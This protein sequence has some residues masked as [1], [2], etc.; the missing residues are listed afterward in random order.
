MDILKD[1][2]ESAFEDFRPMFILAISMSGFFACWRFI[3][4]VFR[5]DY[6]GSS[7]SSS[8]GS[9]DASSSSKSLKGMSIGSSTSEEDE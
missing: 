5:G 3:F 7:Y 4:N 8:S 1:A 6:G 2:L 9:S